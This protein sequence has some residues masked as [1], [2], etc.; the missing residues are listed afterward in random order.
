LPRFRVNLTEVEGVTVLFE[1]EVVQLFEE[2]ERYLLTNRLLDFNPI[3]D[4]GVPFL[5]NLIL[6]RNYAH[7]SGL[8]DF[9]C[10][11]RS[12]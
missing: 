2:F 12:D 9:P 6:G 11:D 10:F 5:D 1:L 8:F 3:E 7:Y 4:D